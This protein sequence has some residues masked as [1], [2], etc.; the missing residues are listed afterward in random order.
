M[1]NMP[2]MLDRLRSS[3]AA[4][5]ASGGSAGGEG[6]AAQGGAAKRFRAPLASLFGQGNGV[7]AAAQPH[8]AAPVAPVLALPQSPQLLMRPWPSPQAAHHSPRSFASPAPQ[9]ALLRVDEDAQYMSLH[10]AV[11]TPVAAPAPAPSAADDADGCDDAASDAPEAYPLPASPSAGSPST[12]TG[13]SWGC[14]C[15]PSRSRPACRGC[16]APCPRAW[17]P[18]SS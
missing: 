7:A 9:A 14:S 6:T 3:A 17:W 11:A 2:S 1:L 12:R 10:A 13:P 16:T 15:S 4:S 5:D 18:S 8:A